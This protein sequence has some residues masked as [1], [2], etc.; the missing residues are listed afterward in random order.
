MTATLFNSRFKRRLRIVVALVL[1]ASAVGPFLVGIGLLT[2]VLPEPQGPAAIIL[3]MACFLVVLMLLWACHE[4]LPL[5][6]NAA[7][8]RHL[9]TRLADEIAEGWQFVGFS[10]G[11]GLRSWEG[12][13]DRDVGFLCLAPGVLVFRGDNFSWVLR[14][15]AIDRLEMMPPT[16]GPPRI[17]VQWHA[18]AE[19]GR[20]FTVASREGGTLRQTAEATHQLYK[21]LEDWVQGTDEPEE[22]ALLGLPPTDLTGSFPLEQPAAGSCLAVASLGLIALLSIWY[23]VRTMLAEQL[24][25]QAALWAGLLTGVAIVASAEVLTYLQQYE[26]NLPPHQRHSNHPVQ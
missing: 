10:P 25:C 1:L 8:R 21:A 19:P 4:R 9:A 20:A 18:P 26:A 3:T 16:G 7:L 23:V 6:G 2:Y 22:V 5:A 13:T 12:E 24:Y 17:F 14:R 15:E 11:S